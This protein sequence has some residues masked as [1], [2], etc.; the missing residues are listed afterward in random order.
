MDICFT[1]SQFPCINLFITLTYFIVFIITIEEIVIVNS[2]IKNLFQNAN[3]TVLD[4]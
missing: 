2:I 3:L 1:V 4:H